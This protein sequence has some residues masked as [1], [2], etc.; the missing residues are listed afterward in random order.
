VNQSS[1][2]K[3]NKNNETVSRQKRAAA[4]D[5]ND[6]SAAPPSFKIDDVEEEDE[7]PPPPPSRLPTVHETNTTTTT[8][9]TTLK[10]SVDKLARKISANSQQSQQRYTN[11]KPASWNY[12]V[13]QIDRLHRG[14]SRV[15]LTMDYSDNGTTDVDVASVRDDRN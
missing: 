7:A 1:K 15:E 5:P 8:R 10:D 4:E 3:M 11:G 13:D 2:K 6:S 14:T 9:T 12:Q